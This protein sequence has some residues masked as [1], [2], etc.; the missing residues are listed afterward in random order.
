MLPAYAKAL[1]AKRRA[2]ISPS[3]FLFV[4]CTW[5]LAKQAHALGQWAI[6]VDNVREVSDFDLGV[7][8]GLPCWVCGPDMKRLKIV[9]DAVAAVRPTEVW[10]VEAA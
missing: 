6:V 2:G 3:G 5:D 1:L 7:C 4:C 8:A 10:E 9:A